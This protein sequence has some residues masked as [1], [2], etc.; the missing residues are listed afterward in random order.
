MLLRRKYNNHAE[1]HMYVKS[2]T[3]LQEQRDRALT[4]DEHQRAEVNVAVAQLVLERLLKK[5]LK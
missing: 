3:E 1:I 2:I 4:A 5:E